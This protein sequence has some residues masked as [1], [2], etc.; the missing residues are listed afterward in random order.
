MHA[1]RVVSAVVVFLFAA[2]SAQATLIDTSAIRGMQPF[3]PA[4][5]M[6]TGMAAADFDRDGDIDFFVP[7]AAGLQHQL[8]RN[9]GNGYYEEIAV[10]AGITDL[11]GA[12]A[13]LWFDY[14]GD[15]ELDCWPATAGA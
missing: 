15:R 12:R 6:G 13:A 3:T 10:S 9:L 1:M 5:G 2:F 4:E 11:G 14:D 8:Y 7:T